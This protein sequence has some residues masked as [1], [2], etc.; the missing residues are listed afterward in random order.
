VDGFDADDD[1][2]VNVDKSP[3]LNNVGQM[4]D[5]TMSSCPNFCG[6]EWRWPERLVVS[7]TRGSSDLS[8]SG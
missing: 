1:L 2:H 5:T 7:D 8:N 6:Y 3:V 4:A